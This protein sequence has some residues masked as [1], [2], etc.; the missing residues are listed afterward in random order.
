MKKSLEKLAK[1]LKNNESFISKINNQLRYLN[2]DN[3]NKTEIIKVLT[4]NIGKHLP[5]H[6]KFAAILNREKGN[7]SETRNDSLSFSFRFKILFK[8]S[9]TMKILFVV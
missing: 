1:L 7:S 9:R 6:E 3:K 8:F 5:S 4:E 2:E